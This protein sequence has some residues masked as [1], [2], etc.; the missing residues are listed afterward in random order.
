MH[1]RNADQEDRGTWATYAK[2]ARIA[3]GLSQT[4]LATKLDTDRTTI[5]RWETSK[6]IPNDGE[7]VTRFASAVGIKDTAEALQAAGIIPIPGGATAPAK[8]TN[9]VVDDPEI[10]IIMDANVSDDLKT[11]LVAHVRERR[12]EDQKR[13]L[14]EI[15]FI[16]RRGGPPLEP[17]T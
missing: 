13:R 12:K 7:L 5:Y 4:E 11:E 14:A 15:D 2:Q 8:P 16:L 10:Q 17:S 6:T 9:Q 3:A 1:V